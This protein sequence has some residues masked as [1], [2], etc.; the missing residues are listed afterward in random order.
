[1]KIT[2]ITPCL[3]S[4]ATLPLTLSSVANQKYKNIE[5]ILID[6][7]SDD[8]TIELLKNNNFKNKKNFFFK[9]K[10]LYDSINY[11][12]KKAKGEII[13]ILNSDDIYNNNNI[14]GN[15]AKIAKKNKSD[16]FIGST[17]YFH[18]RDY[19]KIT[20]YYDTSKFKKEHLTWG[21]MPSHTAS[22]IRKKV[23]QKYGLYNIKMRIASD[24]DFFL[25]VLL[26]N[27]CS[28]K[29]VNKIC[30]RMKTGGLSGKNLSSYLISTSEILRSFKL[31]KLKNNI[32]KVLFRIPAKINQF[33]LFDQKKLN[34]NFNFKILKKYES[35]KYDFKIIQNIKRLNFNKNFILSA[36]NLAYLGSYKSDQIKYNPN[37]VS[38]PDGVFSKVIDRNIKKIPGRDILK[39]IILPRNIKNIYILGNISKKG[40]NFMENKFNKKIKTIN[41]PFGSPMKIFKKIKDKKFSKSDLIFLTIPTPKQEIVADMISKNNKNFKIICIGGSIAIASGDEKQV[42]EILNSYEF[43]WRLRYETKRRFIRLLKTFYYYYLNNIFDNK[44]KNLKIK[45]IT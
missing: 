13:S 20:R 31:N 12:I 25:R 6:G 11:G 41:L 37:L 39:K 16:I 19:K 40:I 38:W 4:A 3:N 17:A 27:N 35:Y 7:G 42:P 28:F 32:A 29:L 10:G 43:L 33:F 18:N 9:N 5:H 2:I 22:F 1:M 44:T 15:I 45:Y 24:F 23:Y 8:G 26:I 36:L 14:I 21:L 34:K 30:T